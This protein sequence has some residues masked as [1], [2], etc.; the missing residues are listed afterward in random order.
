MAMLTHYEHQKGKELTEGLLCSEDR[1]EVLLHSS[2]PGK[3]ETLLSIMKK[4]SY[5]VHRPQLPVVVVD[6]DG[7]DL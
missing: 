1:V 6:D 5:F 7:D 3:S 2:N 4:N